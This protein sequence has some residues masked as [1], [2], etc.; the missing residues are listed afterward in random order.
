M[1]FIA[2]NLFVIVHS[3]PSL[4]PTSRL[5]PMSHRA[6]WAIATGAPY[7]RHHSCWKVKDPGSP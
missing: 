2:V 1:M 6:S 5:R 4:K 3:D 7:R